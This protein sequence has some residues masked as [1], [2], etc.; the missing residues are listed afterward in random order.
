VTRYLARQALD[1]MR[2][3]GTLSEE[4][5]LLHQGRLALSERVAVDEVRAGRQAR[6]HAA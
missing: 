5:E 1:E 6:R 4:W 2:A 3:E